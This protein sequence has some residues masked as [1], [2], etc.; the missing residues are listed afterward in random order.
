LIPNHARTAS[1]VEAQ[2]GEG[3]DRVGVFERSRVVVAVVADGAGGTSGGAVAAQQVVTAVG[4]ALDEGRTPAREATWTQLLLELDVALEPIGQST[5]ALATVS[6]CEVVGASIGDSGVFVVSPERSVELTERQLRKPL[7]GGGVSTVVGFAHP[8][9]A[10]DAVLLATD[11]VL[12][13]AQREMVLSIV[14][15]HRLPPSERCGRIIDVA[16]LA[17]G[18]LSDD[19]GIVLIRPALELAEA[20]LVDAADD[21]LRSAF[22]EWIRAFVPFNDDGVDPDSIERGENGRL[23]ASGKIWEITSQQTVPF[24]ADLRLGPSWLEAFELRIGEHRFSRPTAS[25]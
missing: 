13:Y 3:Q 25:R 8:V 17:N 1:L 24:E 18:A 19:A 9:R 7:L 11:G 4:K 10:R 23:I 20:R 6:A 21:E 2:R 16:R 22:E 12:K 5:A 15:D 14:R